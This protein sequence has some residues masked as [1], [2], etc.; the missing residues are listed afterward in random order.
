MLQ[1]PQ[2]GA[3]KCSID[4]LSL[5]MERQF[6]TGN[7]LAIHGDAVTRRVLAIDAPGL[8]FEGRNDKC[9]NQHSNAACHEYEKKPRHLAPL[10]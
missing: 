3:D 4:C 9:R 5:S 7:V 6:P 1:A 8:E 10:R 2:I